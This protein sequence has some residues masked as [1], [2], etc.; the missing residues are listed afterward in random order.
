MTSVTLKLLDRRLMQ[1][2]DMTSDISSVVLKGHNYFCPLKVFY[3]THN[4]PLLMPLWVIKNTIL[5]EPLRICCNSNFSSKV[6]LHLRRKGGNNALLALCVGFI[7]LF[8]PFRKANFSLTFFF[9]FVF[10][11]FSPAASVGILI[12]HLT[13]NASSFL[14][15]F[16]FHLSSS[17]RNPAAT[18]VIVVLLAARWTLSNIRLLIALNHV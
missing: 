16:I 10:L 4:S 17:Q 2:G 11:F 13:P 18:P 15:P 7:Y 12:S 8:L 14:L 6:E 1:A 3:C 9:C 5:S